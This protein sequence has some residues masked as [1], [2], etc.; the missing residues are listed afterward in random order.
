MILV[1]GRPATLT[2]DVELI[3]SR[4][5]ADVTIALA[6]LGRAN[7]CDRDVFPISARRQN[8]AGR[9][10]SADNDSRR[11]GCAVGVIEL[12]IQCIQCGPAALRNE[13]TNR[14]SHGESSPDPAISRRTETPAAAGLES[15]VDCGHCDLLAEHVR[16][17]ACSASTALD[18]G[19]RGADKWMHFGAYLGL[20]MLFSAV[21]I[22]RRPASGL[23]VVKIVKIV[24]LL[25]TIGAFDEI[26]QPLVGRDCELL[27]WCADVAGALVGSTTVLALA[28]ARRRRAVTLRR[29][30][31]RPELPRRR[32]SAVRNSASA[33]GIDRCRSRG[34]I[35]WSAPGRRAA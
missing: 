20:A 26:T 15:R 22:T 34:T 28:L 27:D 10:K 35:R 23:L 17:H 21:S 33:A 4:T 24:A 6:A 1:A 30:Y 5:T 11:P 25:A 16:G 18:R 9:S 8:C 12:P 29:L 2:A 14:S 32:R 19:R 31:A 7:R 13:W 3:G